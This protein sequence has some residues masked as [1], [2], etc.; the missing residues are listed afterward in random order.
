[1]RTPRW[2]RFRGCVA[3]APVAIARS[4]FIPPRRPTE[5]G[6][7]ISSSLPTKAF[8]VEAAAQSCVPLLGPETI[9]QTIQ[10]G[11]GSPEIAAPII[12]ADRLAAGVA[13]GLGASLRGRGQA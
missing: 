5:S 4:P 3:K 11:L 7:A 12:G 2:E 10:N 1:M 6:P 13:G 9:V 8:D